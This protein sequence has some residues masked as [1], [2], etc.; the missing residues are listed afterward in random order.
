MNYD[1]DPIDEQEEKRRRALEDLEELQ[2]VLKDA[3]VQTEDA[4]GTAP[5]AQSE[6]RQEEHPAQSPEVKR[7]QAHDDLEEL[8]NVL[9]ETPPP[10]EPKTRIIHVELTPKQPNKKPQELPLQEMREEE[11]AQSKAKKEE[12]EEEPVQADEPEPK[13]EQEE[14]SAAQFERAIEE[15]LE[16]LQESAAG[17]TAAAAVPQAEETAQ[18]QTDEP[19]RA[20]SEPEPKPEAP[21]KP[22]KPKPKGE[23]PKKKPAKKPAQKKKTKPSGAQAG[24]KKPTKKM[25]AAERKRRRRMFRIGGLIVVLL[26]VIVLVVSAVRGI[27]HLTRGA[28]DAGSGTQTEEELTASQQESEQYLAIKDDTSLPSYALDYPGLYADAVD[29]PNEESDSKVCYLTFDDG[30]SATVTPTILDVLAEK[31][32]KATFFVVASEIDGNEK[33]IQRIVDEGH[34]L[35]IHCNTHKY[36]ELYTSVEQYLEDFATAYDKIYEITGYRVQGVRFPGGS[37]NVVMQ[38]N[39]TYDEI[40]AEMTRRGFEYY[41]WNANDHDSEGEDYTAEDIVELAVGEVEVSSRN[42]VILLMHD[43]YG[44]ETTAEALPDIIDQ[45]QA[46]GI[47]LAP[48]TNSTRPVHFEVNETTPSELP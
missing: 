41:D 39:D 47:S 13:Q 37:N 44:K 33:L 45:L 43:T 14:S 4:D 5:D 26:L 38:N 15:A 46:E 29:E 48:I 34:T 28:G 3:G 18:E 7:R 19:Q 22:A 40:I 6:A 20:Q 10:E 25:T 12:P 16:Q 24:K 36:S 35:C 1:H 9:N 8:Q 32:V 21:S 2:N 23:T 27:A 42:D 17:Q 11:L 30:P 31:G